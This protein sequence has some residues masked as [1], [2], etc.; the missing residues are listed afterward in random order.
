[1]FLNTV[2]CCIAFV[3]YLISAEKSAI[4]LNGSSLVSHVIFLLQLSR[5]SCVWLFSFP[6]CVCG[7]LLLT[8][9]G[10]VE[11]PGWIA[12]CS[13]VNLGSIKSLFLWMFFLLLS[14]SFASG[15]PITHMVVCLLVFHLCLRL[16]S[17]FFIFFSSLLSLHNLYQPVFKFANS[18]SIVFK[19]IVEACIS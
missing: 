10:S 9:F 18:F 14:F 13:S 7:S 16:C 11:L 4:N 17:C 3:L 5:F 12:Y 15:I 19:S 2:C 8:P 1:M 6:P